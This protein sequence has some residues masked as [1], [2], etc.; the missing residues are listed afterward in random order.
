MSLFD[1]KTAVRSPHSDH[2]DN[3]CFGRCTLVAFQ[4]V[5]A[6]P[7]KKGD[8]ILC[9][10]YVT[11]TQNH[12][13]QTRNSISKLDCR[14]SEPASGCLYSQRE[15]ILNHT[16]YWAKYFTLRCQNCCWVTTFRSLGQS[17]CW[18]MYLGCIPANRN[19]P[20]QEGR[21]NIIS[22][23]RHKHP[24]SCSADTELNFKTRLSDF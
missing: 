6:C 21:F 19:F 23:L 14:I 8:S 13:R 17:M 1:V 4:Q 18:K 24:E 7:N 9:L 3:V 10:L 16:S 11:S 20:Q 12:A 15:I 2:L 22:A 5:K